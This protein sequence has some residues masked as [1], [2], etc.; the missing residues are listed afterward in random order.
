MATTA[1]LIEYHKSSCERH[2]YGRCSTR[3]C[4]VRGGYTK[5]PVDYD[6]ATCEAHE[7]VLALIELASKT[8]TALSE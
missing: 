8:A 4:L 2:I 3:R 7:T 6:I 5:P 1:E